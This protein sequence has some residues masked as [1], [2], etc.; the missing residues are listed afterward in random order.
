MWQQRLKLYPAQNTI[1]PYVGRV[2]GFAKQPTLF[3]Q[4]FRRSLTSLGTQPLTFRRITILTAFL[5]NL[6]ASTIPASA[7]EPL[8]DLTADEIIEHCWAISLELRSK[9]NTE[10][11]RAGHLDTALCLENAIIDYAS[12]FIDPNSMTR[13]EI[14]GKMNQTRYAIGGLYW[15]LYNEHR[16]CSFPSCGHFFQSFHN[17][18]LSKV[19]EE[20]L[21]RVM[22]QRE[23]YR[24]KF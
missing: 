1:F 17:N 4:S 23:D 2:T 13:S 8:P 6:C 3:L 24:G 15:S 9:P 10:A 16:A 20:V 7:D 21:K 19:Y 11:I 14:E 5:M 22:A 18:M 12:D